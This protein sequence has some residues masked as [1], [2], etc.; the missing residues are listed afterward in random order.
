[1]I[2][3]FQRP[4]S[5]KK[6][7]V[8]DMM[9]DFTDFFRSED[10]EYFLGTVVIYTEENGATY[11]IVDGQQRFTT[12]FLMLRYFR[13]YVETFETPQGKLWHAISCIQAR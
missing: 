1:M 7:Q 8:L 3:D 13:K 12:L 9:S 6:D 4:Y 11:S 10:P 5:W 2:P